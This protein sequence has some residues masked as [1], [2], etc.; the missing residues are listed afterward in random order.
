MAVQ[1]R[2]KALEERNNRIKNTEMSAQDDD[3]GAL[4]RLLNA[5]RDSGSVKTRR[6]PRPLEDNTS[7]TSDPNE[8]YN[9]AKD[10]LEQLKAGGFMT[11]PLS[12]TMPTSSQLRRLRRRTER[13]LDSELLEFS[14]LV[15]DDLQEDSISDGA[16]EAND[17]EETDASIIDIPYTHY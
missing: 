4:D 13:G 6:R 16:T 11:T 12:P 7:L 10:M 9:V 17:D 3:D 5:L 2:K 14:P 15:L 1:K 8:T